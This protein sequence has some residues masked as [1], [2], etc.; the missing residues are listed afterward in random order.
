[1]PLTGDVTTLAPS[2]P[3]NSPTAF[4]ASTVT[5]SS[6]TVSY[7]APIGPV[8]AGYIAVRTVG[9]APTTDPVDGTTYTIGGSLGNGVVAYVGT[10]VSFD[11]TS[12]L[13]ATHY[14]YKIY[15]YNGSG[16][17]IDYKITSPLA[18]DVTT[19]G[20]VEPTAQP[21]N[22]AFS[23]ITTTSYDYNFTA[24]T[25]ANVAGYL[26][27]RRTGVAPTFVP[28]DGTVYAQNTVNSDGSKIAI[29]GTGTSYDLTGAIEDTEYFYEIFAFNG[30]GTDINYLQTSPLRGNVTTLNPADDATP[31][32]ITDNT[33]T[34]IAPGTSLKVSVS[35][36]DN[37]S[38]VDEV[39]IEYYPINSVRQG[40]GTLTLKTGT[41]NV[42]EYTIDASYNTEQGIEYNVVASDLAGNSTSD[43]WKSVLVTFTDD[44]LAIP[45]SA[46]TAQDNYRIISIPLNLTKK[47]VADVFG[48]DLG[49]YD[50][51]KYRLFH[52]SGNSTA[53]LTATSTIDVGKGYWFI[54]SDQKTVD[55]GAGVTA[56]VGIDRPFTIPVTNGW[57]QIGN[58]FDSNVDW[59]LVTGDADNADK[60]IGAFKTYE[61]KFSTATTLKKMSGGFVMIQAAGNG[62][63]KI[64]VDVDARLSA[65]AP[66][67]FAQALE[68]D[69][70]A[71][72]LI[73]RS[74]DQ[75]NTFSGF[76]M[77]PD[78]NDQND[79]YDDF[80]LPR[81]VDY[82]EL[83][84]NKKLYGSAFT[85]D[86][87]PTS[88]EHVWEF[89][90][91]SNISNQ[92]IQLQWDNSYFGS[93][94]TQLVL[95]D[96]EQQRAIDMKNET[97]Y[98][99]ERNQSGSF[100]IFF[101]N[102]SFVKSETMPYKP[103]FHSASPVP[104]SG[105][106]TFAFSVPE[107]NGQ[108]TNL[109]VYNLMGQKMANLVD[110]TLDAGYQ[111]AVWNIEDG[112]KPAAGVYIS[113]LKFGDTILQK[114]LVIK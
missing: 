61:G 73:V 62:Q 22:L 19:S 77:H 5:N 12:L 39:T 71:V 27:V 110:R 23:N 93:S 80:T 4:L 42:Y 2:E 81:F 47:T 49:D 21:T 15:A 9:S 97:S 83:N 69:T 59:T 54:A 58:P 108:N 33:Q 109:T 60:T 37:L 36:T 100:K 79:K 18:G 8:V 84:Y 24:S 40:N 67:N 66:V 10:G 82:L 34:T 32:V 11:E 64:P 76:G 78:A 3:A 74:G 91:A 26:I 90:V 46:G 95:W 99:F 94:D 107:S 16:S 48:D 50:K 72:N 14:Y 41:T 44:G 53:E 92:T 28:A 1:L 31:P 75:E 89:E 56:T 65:P 68:S 101:G 87:V 35:V 104:S 112:T 51:S 105:N 13:M 43:V 17:S 55:T 111:Q 86:I 102:D 103:V 7:T 38:G 6:Y 63:L 85:K 29:S 106:V 30:S 113:V 25:S 20:A 98:T 96:V 45:Y 57:N 88:A 114:R 70:W 52:Y